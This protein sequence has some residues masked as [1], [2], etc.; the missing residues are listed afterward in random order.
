MRPPAARPSGS[1]T[2]RPSEQ[3]APQR[4]GPGSTRGRGPLPSTRE[5][6][7]SHAG[8]CGE[9]RGTTGPCRLGRCAPT[10]SR[11]LGT[12]DNSRRHTWDGGTMPSLLTWGN[13]EFP[14]CGGDSLRVGRPPDTADGQTATVSPAPARNGFLLPGGVS[15]GC[16]RKKV[17]TRQ[18]GVGGEGAAGHGGF[19]A[20]RLTRYAAAPPCPDPAR[21]PMKAETAGPRRHWSCCRTGCAACCF[22]SRRFPPRRRRWSWGPSQWGCGTSS[23]VA[24]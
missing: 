10:A 2:A 8:S 1:S 16:G 3:P 11:T 22:V 13:R 17:I 21:I 18:G 6:C 5:P 9:P 23:A 24:P 7:R 15:A 14:G 19:R 4:H 20:A 12:H